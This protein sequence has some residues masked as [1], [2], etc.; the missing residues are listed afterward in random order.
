MDDEKESGIQTHVGP[1]EE[2]GVVTEGQPFPH[3]DLLLEAPGRSVIV[4]PA[5]DRGV[6]SAGVEGIPL[7]VEGGGLV[8]GYGLGRPSAV[9]L[10]LGAYPLFSVHYTTAGKERVRS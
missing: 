5:L 7:Q 3:H 8:V 6:A 10:L 2:R 1:A 9:F 4:V